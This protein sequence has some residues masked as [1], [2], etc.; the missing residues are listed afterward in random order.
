MSHYTGSV[1]DTTRTPDWRTR[2]ACLGH[3]DAM[4]P[5]TNEAEIAYAKGICA[6][7]PV[8]MECLRD[9]IQTGDNQWGIRAGLRPDERRTTAAELKRREAAQET[10]RNAT[11]MV[12][13]KREP[14]KCGTRGG[15]QKHL[16]EKTEICAPCRQANTDADNRLRRT[17]TTKAAA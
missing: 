8:R 15:Y 11:P 16:R 4:H 17:G 13:K 12:R 1:P 2:A 5:D 3:W 7:C 9:A 10:N 6:P 14:A